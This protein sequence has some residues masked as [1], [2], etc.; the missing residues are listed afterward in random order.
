MQEPIQL[1]EDKDEVVTARDP[2]TQILA[3]KELA[4]DS[5]VAELEQMFGG[6]DAFDFLGVSRLEETHSDILAWLLS[7]EGVHSMGDHFLALLLRE[8]NVATMGR[9][10]DAIW[11][12]TSV[13]REWR[14]VVDGK[15]GYLD[16]LLVNRRAKYVC[17][18]ENK[19]FSGEHDE[20][21]T[22]YRK[23]VEHKFTGFNWIYLFLTRHGTLPQRDVEQAHW[24]P[25]D[26]T[27]ILRMV[28]NTVDQVSDYA[29][30]EEVAFLQQYATTLR[31]RIVH[32]T[33]I[34][35]LA[36]RMYL[37]HREAIDLIVENR[38]AHI[39]EVK[40]YCHCAIKQYA[41]W[42]YVGEHRNGKLIRFID[43]SWEEF[44]IFKMEPRSANTDPP[45]LLLI[46]FD[47]REVGMV[48]LLLTLMTGEDEDARKQVFDE[49]QGRHPH[50][51]DHRG[52]RKGGTYGSSHIRLYASE[53][54]LREKDFIEGDSAAWR[55]SI[56][57]R[58]S[59]FAKNEFPPMNKVIV[60]CLRNIQDA[61]VRRQASAG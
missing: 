59:D 35:R 46:D 50:I 8:T 15:I 47:F 20:Q 37:K 4:A 43:R 30:E 44:E 5:N 11:S 55:E 31:R 29:E 38:D 26:Y 36:N 27:T 42:K 53:P 7:P 6:F 33:R 17:A 1:D 39:A 10:P 56:T 23:A 9:L 54:A 28:E 51:F 14:N 57:G 24:Q 48:K 41:N 40:E 45:C 19:L 52:D 34:R 3:L 32:D 61:S 22:R 60:E 13:Q 49:T 58:L 25:M 2:K 21:L 16:I 12:E 18:I